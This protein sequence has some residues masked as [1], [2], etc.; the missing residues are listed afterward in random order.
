MNVVNVVIP[1]QL[2]R[3]QEVDDDGRW[4]GTLKV[5]VDP[6]PTVVLRVEAYA[7]DTTSE[8]V[9]DLIAEAES[10]GECG[11]PLQTIRIDGR[12][13]LLVAVPCGR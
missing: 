7:L 6:S 3:L 5:G 1:A 9:L 2:L 10:L 11:A 4:L 8:V 13:A 12:D